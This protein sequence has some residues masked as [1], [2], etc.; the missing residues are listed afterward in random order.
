MKDKH[1]INLIESTGFGS[2]SDSELETIRTHATECEPCERAAAAARLSFLML[3]ERN[4]EI[5]EP[6]PFFHTRVLANLRERRAAS[7]IWSWSRIWRATGALASSMVATVAALAIL[8][9]V[10]PESQTTAELVEM[11]SRSVYSA[12]EVILNPDELLDDQA[13]DGFVLT[14]LYDSAEDTVK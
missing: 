10:I 3:K 4:T 13:S 7:E 12:E 5:F 8:T 14:T 2:L 9:F 1:I 6:S 11:T